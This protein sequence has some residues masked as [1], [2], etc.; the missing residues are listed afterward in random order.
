MKEIKLVVICLLLMA[1]IAAA[2]YVMPPIITGST[3]FLNV[4]SG[5]MNP[6]M[7]TGDLI[8]VTPV[9]P[10]NIEVGD[11]I[12]HEDP[13]RRENVIITHRVV[14]IIE[15]DDEGVLRFRTKG[16]AN[17][18][19]DPYTVDASDLVGKAAFVIPSLGYFFHYVRG[20]K[21]FL[22]LLVIA[23]AMLIIIDEVRNIMIQSN[24][25]LARKAIKEEKRR[26]RRASRIINY[27]RLL[28][29]F[30]IIAIVFGAISLPFL[31]K[32]GSVTDIN[33][34]TLKIENR[35]ALPSVCIFNI[36]NDPHGEIS[37]SPRYAVL[38]PKSDTKVEVEIMMDAHETDTDTDSTGLEH[39]HALITVSKSPYIMPVFWIDTLAKIN[40][41]L[42]GLVSTTIPPILLTFMLF[43]VWFHRRVK[44]KYKHR[45]HIFKKLKRRLLIA[46][47]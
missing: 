30:C 19:V 25:V 42:P 41:Y 37:I 24:P 12:A 2:I 31:V 44:Y 22:L 6:I 20:T 5:S 17:E 27:K 34:G 21:L 1:A 35:E 7:N 45:R 10:E 40:P 39:E 33:V 18:D 14:E 9:D 13:D 26:K 38:P 4:L 46:T 43:P 3:K 15:E 29:L 28:L 47:F 11:I 8:V 16:D 36:I 23:P 32:S